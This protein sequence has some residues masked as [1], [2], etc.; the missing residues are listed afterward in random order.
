MNK[1]FFVIFLI[2]VCLFIAAPVF[3]ETPAKPPEA[4]TL[5][6][7][8]DKFEPV[9]FTHERHASM[10]SNC[11]TCHHEH[12]NSGSLPC[13]DCHSIS[14]SVFKDSVTRSFLAC[15]NC[16]GTYSPS[17][18]GMPGLKVAYHS[19]CFQCHRGMSDVGIDPKGCAELCHARKEVKINQ[20]IK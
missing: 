2:G 1:S 7:I 18:P 5:D 9:I 20:G 17:K 16:H 14:P 6:S 13:K 3:A 4:I 8:S 12:G 19:K 15:K 11:E 10:A